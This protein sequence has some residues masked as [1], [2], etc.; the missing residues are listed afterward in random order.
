MPLEKLIAKII[1]K[2]CHLSNPSIAQI[3]A[4]AEH[5]ELRKD[6]LLIEKGKRS[7]KEY[8]VIDGIAKSYLLNL[9]NEEVTLSFFMPESIISPH[10]TR[11][12]DERSMVN[13]RALTPLKIACIDAQK[14]E[15]LMVDNLEVRHF[16]NTVLRN[17]LMDKVEKEIGLA[18]LPAIERLKIL[19]QKYPNL[20]NLVPH[21]DIASYL[22]ITH[23][24]LSRLRKAK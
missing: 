3:S 2:V 8:F 4:I 20:E 11:T 7:L 14:F 1:H 13:I 5:K 12:R 18:S 21:S 24:S 6:Q 17:E 15:Q 10:T 19:R 22:G 16:G 9:D 23:V